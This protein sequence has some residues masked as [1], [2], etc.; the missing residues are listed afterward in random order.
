MTD[1]FINTR[2]AIDKYNSIV[3][4]I[5]NGKIEIDDKDDEYIYNFHLYLAHALLKDYGPDG[6]SRS[7]L[8]QV[9]KIILDVI[10]E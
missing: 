8:K 3:D 5:K 6:I 4:C 10:D 7:E 9:A 2:E 1:Y